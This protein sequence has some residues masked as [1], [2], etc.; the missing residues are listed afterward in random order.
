MKD[1][2][3]AYEFKQFYPPD[4]EWIN[5]GK[6]SII[7]PRGEFIVGP[8]EKKEEI[9]YVEIDLNVIL[10]SKRMFDVAG[11]YARPDI[12]QFSVN[13]QPYLNIKPTPS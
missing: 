9:L 10:A 11:H 7:N 8:L 12:F 6:S 2:P 13:Q 3:D 5:P 1:I 4:K